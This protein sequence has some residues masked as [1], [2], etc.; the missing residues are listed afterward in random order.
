[1][2]R[3]GLSDRLRCVGAVCAAAVIV[4]AILFLLVNR[5][6][7]RFNMSPSLPIG[8]YIVNSEA[9]NLVEFCPAEPYGTL[10]AARGYRSAGNCPDGASPLMKPVAARAG[11]RVELTPRAIA[12]NG[13]P[14]PNTA[15][16]LADTSGRPLSH[17]P[18]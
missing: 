13:K 5:L 18:F 15:P 11:G 7:L 17:F 10:A 8:I 12:V 1:M 4:I 3:N 14:L 6:G 9:T 16:R 2:T